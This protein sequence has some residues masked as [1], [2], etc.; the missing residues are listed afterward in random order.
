MKKPVILVVEDEAAISEAI[1]CRLEIYEAFGVDVVRTGHGALRIIGA[2]VPD[3][4]VLDATLPDV[5]GSEVC[6][7]IR[8][9]ERTTELPVIMLGEGTTGIGP[10]AALELGV[11]D[12]LRKP[13]DPR[14]LEARLKAVLR[15]RRTPHQYHGRDHF[16]GF[17]IE[18]DFADV[19]VT[20][21]GS[22]VLL[23]KREF[24]LLRFFVHN[25][26]QVLDRKT[27][28]ANVWGLA[29]QDCRIVDAAIWKLRTKLNEA[30]RQIETVIGFGYRFNEP[31]KESV[32]HHINGVES[33]TAGG[34]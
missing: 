33:D 34:R 25:C 31:P 8:S 5:P 12:Y 24:S 21:D 6:R 13:F 9:R 26:N 23:T 4:V 18:A 30:R 14:E 3:A 10:I 32:G 28:L 15:R 20:I 22:S 7:V 17:H 1:K 27:L 11:D 2:A 16:K 19:S 29:G